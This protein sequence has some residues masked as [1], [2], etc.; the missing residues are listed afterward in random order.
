M[1]VDCFMVPC[2]CTAQCAVVYG[3]RKTCASN[4]ALLCSIY[5]LVFAN[6]GHLEGVRVLVNASKLRP[7]ICRSNEVYSNLGQRLTTFEMPPAPY[8]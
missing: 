3:V 4:V 1:R 5:Q 8:I 7:S 2:L 6:H